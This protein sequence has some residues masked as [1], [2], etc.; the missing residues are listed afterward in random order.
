M[1]YNISGL[2]SPSILK[3]DGTR[4]LQPQERLVLVTPLLGQLTPFSKLAFQTPHTVSK[5][6]SGKVCPYQPS[7]TATHPLCH[8]EH[9]FFSFNIYFYLFELDLS[10]STQDL[11]SLLW[12]VGSLVA[13]RELLVVT[14]GI[15]FPDQGWN[16]GPLH[17]EPAD[18]FLTFHIF[19]SPMIYFNIQKD[20]GLQL[21]RV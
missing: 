3:F 14:C 15:Q 18:T 16:P 21:C 9:F 2:R 5:R 7:R 13:A 12:H 6:I 11:Q 10:C 20:S 4:L 17:W 8:L 19:S 1:L